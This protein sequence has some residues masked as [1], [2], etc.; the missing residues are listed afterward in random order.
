MGSR[1]GLES[2]PLFGVEAEQDAAA[3]DD[4]RAPDQV[5]VR[6]HQADRF[7]AGGRIL[8]HVSFAVQLIPGVQERQV[9]A[10]ADELVELLFGQT[11]V[12]V[13]GLRLDAFFRQETPGFAAG[14]S[15]GFGVELHGVSDPRLLSWHFSILALQGRRVCSSDRFLPT[16]RRSFPRPAGG[17]NGR[18]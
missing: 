1:S 12:E 5:R 18:H 8:L 15:S 10:L 9:V 14:G 17:A 11:P 13:D 2:G 4:E 7:F 3:A 6:R 16:W